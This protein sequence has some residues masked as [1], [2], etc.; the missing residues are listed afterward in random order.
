[1]QTE[2]MQEIVWTHGEQRER[3][4]DRQMRDALASVQ[5]PYVTRLM[6]PNGALYFTARAY[7]RYAQ[8]ALLAG[9]SGRA[10]GLVMRAYAAR[11]VARGSK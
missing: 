3:I 1:M 11:A 4:A 10:L 9:D 2:P 7:L 5:R 8:E 6:T